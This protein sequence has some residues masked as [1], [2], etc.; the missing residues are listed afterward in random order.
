MQTCIK[1]LLPETHET[2]TFDSQGICSVCANYSFKQDINWNER[3]EIFS[4]APADHRG[5]FKPPIY[6]VA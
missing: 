5:Y 4:H 2:I 3:K 1:C 6:G